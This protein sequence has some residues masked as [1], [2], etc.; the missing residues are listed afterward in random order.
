[1]KPPTSATVKLTSH[2]AK[3]R[4]HSQY[5]QQPMRKSSSRRSKAYLTTLRPMLAGA[6][7]YFASVQRTSVPVF[8]RSFWENRKLCQPAP[9]K[10]GGNT[11]T[12]VERL[13]NIVCMRYFSHSCDNK[14]I[15]KRK[16]N[17]LCAKMSA[18]SAASRLARN[19][20]TWPFS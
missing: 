15:H 10:Y 12:L 13:L 6:K 17:A 14:S 16:N 1:M 9:A 3:K 7:V 4:A 5:D 20:P 11:T 2:T 8:M 18:N 19:P